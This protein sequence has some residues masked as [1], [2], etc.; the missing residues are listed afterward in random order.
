MT[1]IAKVLFRAFPATAS[2][3]DAET[4]KT[5]AMF[6]GVGLVVSLLLATWGLD[7]SPGFF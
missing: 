2:G 6:C 1:A 7:M 5:I 3:F 4:I